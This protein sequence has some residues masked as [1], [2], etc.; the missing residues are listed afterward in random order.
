M[1]NFKPYHIRVRRNSPDSCTPSLEQTSLSILFV[2]LPFEMS[3][4]W[5][6]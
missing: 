2:Q 6:R 5:I 3:D 4:T 1:K